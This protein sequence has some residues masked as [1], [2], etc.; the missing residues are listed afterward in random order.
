M[1]LK[2]LGWKEFFEQEFN[3]VRSEDLF[4]ARVVTA[5]REK[6][7]VY[8]NFGEF[9][10][11]LTGKLRFN[12]VSISELPVVGDWVVIRLSPEGNLAIIECVL[13]RLNKFSRKVVG[14]ETVEQVLVSNIDIVFIVNGLDHDYNL[15]RIERYLTLALKSNI[16][17]V[18]VLNKV[19]ICPDIEQKVAEVKSVSSGIPVCTI[20]ALTNDG[21]ESLK[22]YIKAGSTVNFLGSSGVGK[23]TIINQLLGEDRLKVGPVREW[24]SRGRHITSR[25]ELI[26]LPGGGMVI[27]NPGLRE[28]QLWVDESTVE[29]EFSDIKELS[30]DC[31]FRDCQHENEPECAV[32]DAVE[33]GKLDSAR[34]QSYVKLKKEIKYLTTRKEAKSHNVKV[35]FE[36]KVSKWIK[37][38]Q[39]YREKNRF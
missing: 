22:Q 10:A 8:S 6:Y 28:I 23:S 5:Q 24:D 2:E 18:I 13:P 29:D 30:V 33:T 31:K 17:T 38:I 19:D 39:K 26:M 20:S 11:E 25:R 27:D 21:I 7:C 1:E 36:K 12:A 37:Q 3:K 9:K 15:R 14:R 4:P 16:N 34:F 35:K 32:K